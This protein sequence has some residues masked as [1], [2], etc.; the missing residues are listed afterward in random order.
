VLTARVEYAWE[1]PSLEEY[2][3]NR[4]SPIDNTRK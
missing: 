4:L 2:L 3:I 1:A